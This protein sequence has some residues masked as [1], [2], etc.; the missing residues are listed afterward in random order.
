MKTSLFAVIIFA[1]ALS[2]CKLKTYPLQKKYVGE[3]TACVWQ[4]DPYRCPPYVIYYNGTQKNTLLL[5]IKNNRVYN[6]V[7]NL[8]D[9]RQANRSHTGYAAI[10]VVDGSSNIYAS[11]AHFVFLFHHSTILAGGGVAAAGEIVATNGVITKIT[12]CSG[13]YTPPKITKDAVFKLLQDKGY[14]NTK[15]ITFVECKAPD[16]IID[17]DYNEVKSD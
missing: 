9:T 14:K 2:G 13:H 6:S 17:L 11:N 4:N 8:F 7:G 16:L 10:F 1:V 12:N 15:S 3:S 5:N